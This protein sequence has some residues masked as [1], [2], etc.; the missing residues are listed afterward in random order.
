MKR[1]VV[2]AAV[3]FAM[4]ALLPSAV[5]ARCGRGLLRGRV[6]HRVF[7]RRGHR[8]HQHG[9]AHCDNGKCAK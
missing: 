5:E 3:L 6:F 9:K 7:H 4:F 1:V 8:V 2:L